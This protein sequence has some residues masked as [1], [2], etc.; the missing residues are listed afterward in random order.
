MGGSNEEESRV[1][2]KLHCHRKPPLP[3]FNPV[4]RLWRVVGGAKSRDVLVPNPA[5]NP[6]RL[7][8][9]HLE[10][11]TGLSEPTEHVVA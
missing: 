7:D 4:N 2:L 3:E 9:A 5:A 11:L 6:A 1:P 8:Q 10:P